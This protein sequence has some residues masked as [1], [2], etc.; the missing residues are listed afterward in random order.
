M[1]KERFNRLVELCENYDLDIIKKEY[2]K[3]DLSYYNYDILSYVI[4]DVDKKDI[5]EYIGS[6]GG[7]QKDIKDTDIY[8]LLMHSDD[9]N[10]IDFIIK[11]F[12]IPKNKIKD[13]F[14]NEALYIMREIIFEQ[15]DYFSYL[16]KKYIMEL[17]I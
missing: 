6:L 10:Y 3:E 5:V 2:T 17:S 15:N 12:N 1:N 8:E 11:K 9:M 13:F 16:Y 4:D 14:K 7:Y